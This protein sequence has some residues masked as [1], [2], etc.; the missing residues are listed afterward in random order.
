M[1]RTRQPSLRKPAIEIVG[2]FLGLR[3]DDDERVDRGSVLVVGVD[4]P[5]QVSRP[6]FIAS[7]I[8]AMVASSTRKGG[9]EAGCWAVRTDA[10]MAV[11]QRAKRT[12]GL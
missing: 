9:G 6:A 4:P 1:E 10:A 11:R 3:V 7:W 12:S 2:Q 5:R 8:C